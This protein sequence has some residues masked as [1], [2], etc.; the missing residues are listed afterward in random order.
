MLDF[1]A[2]IQWLGTA[3]SCAGA[4]IWQQD[5]GPTEMSLISSRVI[6]LASIALVV[7]GAGLFNTSAFAADEGHCDFSFTYG[8]LDRIGFQPITVDVTIKAC[9]APISEQVCQMKAEPSIL[10]RGPSESDPRYASGPCDKRGVTVSCIVKDPGFR[11][12]NKAAT[13][14]FYALPK[15]DP[16]GKQL[17]QT[18]L[19]TGFGEI[20]PNFF[21]GQ[22]LTVEDVVRLQNKG[23][24]QSITP[25]PMK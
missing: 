22:A 14:M 7:T 21:W 11:T 16:Q 4:L 8:A 9:Q 3:R 12:G 6:G 17:D 2:Y 5:E 19:C 1:V 20:G 10:G 18:Y 13:T 23:A 25:R 15:L 24:G